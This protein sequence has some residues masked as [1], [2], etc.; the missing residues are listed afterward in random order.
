N[1]NNVHGGGSFRVEEY[2][3]PEFEVMVDAPSEPVML[4]EPITAKISAKYYFGSPVTNATVRY[5]VTRT[6]HEARWYP[7]GEWD[8]FYGRGYWWFAPA[9][10]WYPGFSRWG[11]FPPLPP[12]HW[13]PPEPPEIVA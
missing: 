8:W 11:C 1:H 6:K 10:E 4:G 7:L 5:K 2:K 13:A 9:R 3:K 12:W